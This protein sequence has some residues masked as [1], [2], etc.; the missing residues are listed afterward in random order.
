MKINGQE[1]EVSTEPYRDG[2]RAYAFL[3]GGQQ[4][5]SAT[6]PTREGAEAD[7]AQ[8]LRPPAPQFNPKRQYEAKAIVAALLEAVDPDEDSPASNVERYASAVDVEQNMKAV[9]RWLDSHDQRHE[10]HMPGY[11]VEQAKKI[12]RSYHNFRRFLSAKLKR[13]PE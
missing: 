7:L 9:V 3:P 1:V 5:A 2:W 4:K 10:V 13:Y 6:C 11:T 12:V 8:Q